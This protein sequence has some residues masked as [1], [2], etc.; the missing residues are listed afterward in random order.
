MSVSVTLNGLTYTLPTTDETGWGPSVT[1]WA[2]AVS[3]SVL[4]KTGG[5]FT[6]TAD[7]DFGATYG[8]K[9]NYF[10]SRT[11][12]AASAGV[13]RLARADSAKWRN[14]ANGADLTLGVDSSNNLEWESVDVATAATS[15]PAVVTLGF[16]SSL[17]DTTIRYACPGG[18]A[19]AAGTTELQI[20]APYA[21]VMRNLYVKCAS[22]PTGTCTFTPRKNGSDQIILAVGVTS[23]NTTG[24]NTSGSVTVAAGDLIAVKFVMTSGNAP[25]ATTVSFQITKV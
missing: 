13:L 9:S 3:S 14:E 22:A 20:P 2:Q 11:A 10:T 21:G 23:G 1:A 18:P 15:A 17:N 7:A 25:G 4:Q 24:S 6:L 16:L 12:N 8:L 19:A 5:V